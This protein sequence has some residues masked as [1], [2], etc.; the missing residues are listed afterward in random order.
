MIGVL[1][2]PDDAKS[3]YYIAA[4][5]VKWLESAGARAIAIPFHAD[6]ELIESIFNQV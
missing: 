6:D 4:S 2:T 5:Y 1:S 3:Y